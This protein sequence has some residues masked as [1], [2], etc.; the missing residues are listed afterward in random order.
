MCIV[1]NQD[2]THFIKLKKNSQNVY[3]PKSGQY[4]FVEKI[5]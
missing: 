4:T 1:L 3:C 2:N 5:F